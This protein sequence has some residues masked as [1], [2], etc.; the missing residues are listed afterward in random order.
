LSTFLTELAEAI[1]E[2]SFQAIEIVRL[3]EFKQFSLDFG[4]NELMHQSLQLFS[5][6]YFSVLNEFKNIS[7]VFEMI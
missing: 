4:E 6:I 5:G 7:R 2:Q 3:L 1:T